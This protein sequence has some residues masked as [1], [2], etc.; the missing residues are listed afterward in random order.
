MGQ[1]A[2][3]LIPR[4]LDEPPLFLIWEV[5]S[6]LI[7][8]F[9]IGFGF[10]SGLLIPLSLVGYF[11]TKGYVSMKQ[12]GGPGLIIRIGYWFLPQGNAFSIPSHIRAYFR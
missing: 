6:A 8:I 11:C 5:D 12:E 10:I 7:L 1:Q 4:T 2:N 3:F 9:F